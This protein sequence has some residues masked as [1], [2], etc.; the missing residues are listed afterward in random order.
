VLKIA[1]EQALAQQ[2]DSIDGILDN[3]GVPRI[4]TAAPRISSR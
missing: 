2:R 3:F 4:E 1:V